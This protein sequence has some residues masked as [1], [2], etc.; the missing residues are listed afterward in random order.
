[1][2]QS[3]ALGGAHNQLGLDPQFGNTAS[4]DFHLKVGSPAID[5]ANPSA[6]LSIDCDG[7]ARPQG[8][9]RDVGAFEYKP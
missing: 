2:P 8:P 5:A 3:T 1:M 7:T 6:T 9:A 4:S